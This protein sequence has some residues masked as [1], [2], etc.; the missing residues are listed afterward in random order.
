MKD[1]FSYDYMICE[2][3]GYHYNGS[4]VLSQLCRFYVDRIR[5][6][7]KYGLYQGR[8]ILKIV[9]RCAFNDSCLTD[10]ESIAIIETCLDP[11]LDNILMEVNYNE[12]W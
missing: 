12:S 9:C 4:V 11:M 7:F 2:I 10:A 6:S 8:E 1:S 5:S 3:F